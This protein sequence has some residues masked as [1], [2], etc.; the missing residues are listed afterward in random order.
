MH[1]LAANVA[2]HGA[3]MAAL[4]AQIGY[5]PPA[6]PAPAALK[7]LLLVVVLLTGRSPGD[8]SGQ[9]KP[10]RTNECSQDYG[11]CG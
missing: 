6:Q 2:V 8:Q 5:E 9:H 1:S 7:Q 11:Q 10:G 4:L 3:S